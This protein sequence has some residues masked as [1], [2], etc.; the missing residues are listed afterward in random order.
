MGVSGLARWLRRRYRLSTR[1]FADASFQL[2][3]NLY[4]DLH[5]LLYIAADAS[6]IQD[7]VVTDEFFSCIGTFLENLVQMVMPTDL[8]YI[9]ADGVAAFAKSQVKRARAFLFS[10]EKAESAFDQSVLT[11]GTPFLDEVDTRMK[12]FIQRKC[13]SDPL[14]SSVKVVYS[15][16]YTP[17][18]GDD[19]I[20]LQMKEE[21][22][23]SHAVFSNDSDLIRSSLRTH[24]SRIVII[25]TPSYVSNKQLL[26][27]GS[28]HLFEVT[29]VSLLREYI[30]NEMNQ[31][32]DLERSID[33]F[34]ALTVF[35]GGDFL[36]PFKEI[37]IR[38]GGFDLLI[39]SYKAVKAEMGGWLI[40]D[41]TF[42]KKFLCRLLQVT[43]WS[44][45]ILDTAANREQMLGGMAYAQLVT[46]FPD[47]KTKTNETEFRQEVEKICNAT[48]DGFEFVWNTMNGKCVSWNWM[49]PYQDTPPLLY[50]TFHAAHE[51]KFISGE[52]HSPFLNI[53]FG[54]LPN[55]NSGLP[56]PLMNLTEPPSPISRFYP[57]EFPIVQ[58]GEVWNRVPQ[59]PLIDR[60][61]IVS[62]YN[63]KL[64][65]LP[66][67][68]LKRNRQEEAV[69]FEPTAT[70]KEST[71]P[72]DF[73]SFKGKDIVIKEVCDDETYF[74]VMF[75]SASGPTTLSQ[76]KSLLNTEVQYD[77]PY[78]KRGRVTAVQSGRETITS[79][80]TNRDL[81]KL[82]AMTA[83]LA[84][85]GITIGNIYIVCEITPEGGTPIWVPIQLLL[86]KSAPPQVEKPQRTHP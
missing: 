35:L 36:P 50:L 56:E 40:E 42:N 38:A 27:P 37:P 7:P 51:S 84:K 60:D 24:F 80:G 4:V 53:L 1:G 83:N 55:A 45:P 15:G 65:E 30:G 57:K 46:D 71:A 62:A 75:T 68:S 77:W 43:V 82:T 10:A 49:F 48:L 8:I 31:G 19:K 41:D 44:L 54:H 72:V 3:N 74:T 58:K 23:K 29:H 66:P 21:P 52:P 5:Q 28:K 22:S 11:V 25:H 76:A 14:W 34:L 64:A 13:G 78:C 81:V 6:A 63:A 20:V 70:G 2:I 85:S 32:R 33:D 26:V 47:L 67:E 69:V 39:N 79:D 61:E 9:A 86:L 73:P 18:E 16:F 17:C 59:I 12:D